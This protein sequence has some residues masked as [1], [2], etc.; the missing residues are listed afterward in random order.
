MMAASH[1]GGGA[2]GYENRSRLKAQVFLWAISLI[3][4][5]FLAADTARHAAGLK[6]DLLVLV[7]WIVLLMI[8]SVSSIDG[9]QSSHFAV[10]EPLITAA[11]LVLPPVE[12]GLVGLLGG[13]DSREIQGRLPLNKAMFNRSQLSMMIYIGSL[14]AHHLVPHPS[15]APYVLPLAFLVLLLGTTLNYALIPFALSLEHS[16]SVPKVLQRLRLGAPIDF[17][18]TQVA[19]A[20]LGA[21]LATFYGAIHTWALLAFLVPIFLARQA[22]LRSQMFLETHRAYISQNEVL[23]LLSKRMS[24]ERS[25]ERRLIA[26]DLHDEVMQPLFKVSLMA[27]VLSSELATGRLLEMEEDLPELVAAAETASSTLRDA[28]G[29]L[30]KSSLGVDGLGKALNRLSA[31]MSF[32][33]D[34]A[35]HI[36]ASPL[37]V[38]PSQELA[39]YQIA[40]EAVSNAVVHSSASHIWVELASGTWGVSL[41]VRDDGVGFDQDEIPRGHYG[42]AIMRERAAAIGGYFS[43][44]TSNGRGCRV[45]ITISP[46]EQK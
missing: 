34:A 8:S 43:L 44:E 14:I 42:I 41:M 4:V 31:V 29:D 28:I 11:A 23:T 2:I 36:E 6:S 40:K 12:A 17:S 19:G 15:S 46:H 33:T 37:V 1:Q 45:S 39:L 21:M 26:A 5:S 24:E 10:N 35:I 18:L 13:L 16:C 7:P 9:W 38:D 22:L 27:H 20:V 30:R 3:W 25:D 32:S